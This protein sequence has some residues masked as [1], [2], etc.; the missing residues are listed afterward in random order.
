MLAQ[1]IETVCGGAARNVEVHLC[2]ANSLYIR[3]HAPN[4]AVGQQLGARILKMPELK[5][6]QVS[7]E[8]KLT[9]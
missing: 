1:R 4:A 2:S 7:L 5:P 9:E 3:V 6:Y 8:V